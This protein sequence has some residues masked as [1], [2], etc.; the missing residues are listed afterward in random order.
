M[1]GA[2]PDIADSTHPAHSTTRPSQSFHFADT[3][4][5]ARPLSK[6]Y[7]NKYIPSLSANQSNA[8]PKSGNAEA[9]RES[10]AI[11]PLSHVRFKSP[12]LHV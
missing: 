7:S 6:A 11:D 10:Q 2:S 12:R 8:A 9:R 5:A 3:G 1:P 4:P